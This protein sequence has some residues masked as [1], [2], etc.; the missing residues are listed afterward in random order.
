MIPKKLLFSM[1][2]AALL[3]MSMHAFAQEKPFDEVSYTPTETTFKLFAPS[4]A[5]RVW[6]HIY[7]R[8]Y[9][10]QPWMDKRKKMKLVGKDRW[11]ITVK[12]DL[13][14]RY[15]TFE[16]CDDHRWGM[17]CVPIPILYYSSFGETPGVFAKAVGV[18]GKRG[19]VVDMRETNPQGWENDRRPALKSPSDLIIY[20]LHH[21]DFS[22]DASSGL[23]YKGK[24]LALTEPKAIAYLKD[25]GVNAIHILPSFDYASV[26]ESQPNTPQY[27][28]GYDPLNYNVPEGSYATDV[29]NPLTRIREFKQMVQTLHQAGIRVILDVVYNHTYNI[30]GSAFQRTYPDYFYRKTEKGGGPKREAYR[31]NGGFIYS[32]P[33]NVGTYSNG[34]GCGNETAS[35]QPMMRQFMVE[36]VKYWINEYHIDGFRFDLMG[37]HDME[38]MNL[39]R[40]EVD[41]IDPSIFIYGEGWSAGSC[42]YPP[43]KLATK[44]NVP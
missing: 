25:L 21:R 37:V 16:V 12:G 34:S 9:T 18:N 14:G 11:Q 23:L 19:V 20:E 42:A 36:S 33:H 39:L 35:E 15:Y 44:A 30:E 8:D 26:D 5:K 17:G 38:T 13:K 43:E 4:A 1:A 31:L 3:L 2:V 22:I 6:L 40:A 10:E 32:A 29:T 24:Y 28:W 27:N 7:G 41:K